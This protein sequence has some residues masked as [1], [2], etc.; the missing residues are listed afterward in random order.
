[1]LATCDIV[2]HSAA[3]VSFDSPL[4]SAVE[5]NL[6][7]PTRIADLLNELGVAPHLVAVSTCYVAGNRRGSAPEELVSA[8]PFDLGL[9]WRVEVAAARRLRSDLEAAS[10][11]PDELR[12]FRAAART[13]LGAPGNPALAAKTEQL[14]ER[15]VSDQLVEAGRA[16]AASLVVARRLRLHQG[17]RRAGAHRDARRR[18]RVDRAPVDHRVGVGGTVPR[19]DPRLPDGGAGHHLLRPRPVEGVPRRA[20]GNRRRDPGRPRRRRH[21]RR[22]RPRPGTGA[23]D[24]AGRVGFGE[25]AQVP[26]ARRQRPLVVHRAS[27]LRRRG[28]ADRRAGVE[29]PRSRPGA[30]ATDPGEEGARPRREGAAGAAA[31]GQA[32]RLVGAARREADRG[33][34]GA[35]VRRAVRPLHRVRGDLRR[36]PPARQLGPV[37][38]GR[39]GRRSASTRGSS[40]G[41]PT[42]TRSTFRRWCSTP[43]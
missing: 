8:G 2:I 25:P 19:L 24:H 15:W 42:S 20:G 22:R 14:R 43:G 41:R 4:D 33:V 30:G 13:E 5:V 18:A 29:L 11:D 34:A 35:R 26:D 32:G 31:A 37:D 38:A 36:R 17:A 6:L 40:T 23:G 10:R 28:P 12:G 21:H 27:A 9:D 1:M 39:P 16:R 7:G 3:A